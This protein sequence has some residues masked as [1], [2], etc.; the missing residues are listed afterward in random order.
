MVLPIPA[1][2]LNK[3]LFI[4]LYIVALHTTGTYKIHIYIFVFMGLYIN[5]Y[6]TAWHILFPAKWNTKPVPS[7]LNQHN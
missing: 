6:M 1:Q 7:Q 3:T 5:I 2:Q 4:S